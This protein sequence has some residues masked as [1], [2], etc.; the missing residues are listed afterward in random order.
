MRDRIGLVDAELAADVLDLRRVRDL[1]RQQVGRVAADEV[2]QEKHQQHHAEQRRDKLPQAPYYVREQGFSPRI[3][4]RDRDTAIRRAAPGAWRTRRRAAA[5][6]RSG[7]ARR[8]ATIRCP[9]S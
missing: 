2:E 7:C 4:A 9:L 6:A 5:A 3:P 8:R 1:A